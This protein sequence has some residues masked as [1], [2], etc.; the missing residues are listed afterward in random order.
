MPDGSFIKIGSLLSPIRLSRYVSKMSIC[1][2]SSPSSVDTT[3]NIF[4]DLRL[5]VGAKIL[6]NSMSG[7]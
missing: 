7:I 4:N 5:M 1:S 6:S 2:A 3:K